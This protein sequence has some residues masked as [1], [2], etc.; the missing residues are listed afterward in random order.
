MARVTSRIIAW[1]SKEERK[2]DISVLQATAD[3]NRQS[4]VLAPV[5]TGALVKSSQIN[6]KGSCHYSVTFGGSAVPYARRRHFENLKNP[7]TLYYLRRAGDNVKRV[8]ARYFR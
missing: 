1:G 3:I 2:L 5:L 6:R 4:I 7:Q 8:F